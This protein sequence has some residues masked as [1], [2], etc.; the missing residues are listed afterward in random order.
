MSQISPGYL[1]WHSVLAIEFSLMVYYW[2]LGIQVLCQ[3]LHVD[4]CIQVTYF[5]P[6]PILKP[7]LVSETLVSIAILEVPKYLSYPD[8]GGRNNIGCVK[9]ICILIQ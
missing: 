7:Q 5:K 2:D 6:N 3:E 9:E 4:I 1:K 8:E